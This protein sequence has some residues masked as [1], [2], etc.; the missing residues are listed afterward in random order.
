MHLN[1]QGGHI[2]S[3]VH[4]SSLCLLTKMYVTGSTKQTLGNSDTNILTAYGSECMK[5]IAWVT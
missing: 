3:V 1:M 2:L 4:V 5:Y